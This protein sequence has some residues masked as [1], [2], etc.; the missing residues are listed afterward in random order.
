[1]DMAERVAPGHVAHY[2]RTPAM[3][4]AVERIPWLAISACHLG[5]RARA[6]P[7]T[8]RSW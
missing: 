3:S 4:Q 1:M 5:L 2:I 6:A 7:G 8:N